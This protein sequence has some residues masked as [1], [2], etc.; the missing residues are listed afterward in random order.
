MNDL[1]HQIR[2]VLNLQI[3]PYGNYEMHSYKVNQGAYGHLEV[4]RTYSQP[5]MK[6]EYHECIFVGPRGGCK[7]NYK[8]FY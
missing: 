6:I 7:T 3:P 8:S 4:E 2:T 1:D 5:G